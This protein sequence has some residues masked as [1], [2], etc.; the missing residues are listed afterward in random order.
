MVVVSYGRYERDAVESTV[1]LHVEPRERPNI[2][3]EPVALGWLGAYH[4]RASAI[5]GVTDDP[6]GQEV[7]SLG[8]E[9]DT[10]DV[11]GLGLCCAHVVL[12]MNWIARLNT[13]LPLCTTACKP[14][15]T[16]ALCLSQRNG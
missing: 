12:A 3:G 4:R 11:P 6:F 2:F 13:T 1:R 8:L 15:R 5:V 10:V 7:V 16:C 14:V 9:L